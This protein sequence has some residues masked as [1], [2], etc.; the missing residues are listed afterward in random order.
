[1][2]FEFTADVALLICGQE[3]EL[4]ALIHGIE[5]AIENPGTEAEGQLLTEDGVIP[6]RIVCEEPIDEM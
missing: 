6:L 4:R 1:M 2:N 3:N 5:L